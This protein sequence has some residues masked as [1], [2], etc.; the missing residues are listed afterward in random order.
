MEEGIVRTAT[1]IAMLYITLS[2]AAALVIAHIEGVSLMAALLESVSAIGTVG[3]STGITP[4]IGL[5][6]KMLLAMLMLFG[7]VGSITMLLAFSSERAAAASK[8]PMEKI[9]LG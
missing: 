8:L 4:R 3:L 6:S 1:C 2:L 9:Q 5:V 7:R